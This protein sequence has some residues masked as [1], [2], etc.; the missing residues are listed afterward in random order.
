[1]V[2]MDS[3]LFH[4]A[5]DIMRTRDAQLAALGDDELMHYGR[6]GMKWNENIYAED[7]EKKRRASAS[8]GQSQYAKQLQAEANK[9]RYGGSAYNDSKPE[10]PLIPAA[11]RLPE[12]P[13]PITGLE[14]RFDNS[15]S[16]KADYYRNKYGSQSSGS[17][18]DDVENGRRIREQQRAQREAAAKYGGPAYTPSQK[19]L[20]KLNEDN[21]RAKAERQI[22]EAKN[23]N[24]SEENQK[25][26]AARERAKVQED[27]RK[28]DRIGLY[29]DPKV[30]GSGP[31]QNGDYTI[32]TET[33]LPNSRANDVNGVTEG[34]EHFNLE[35]VDEKSD[36]L[37]RARDID[38]WHIE[39]V[40]EPYLKEK[41]ERKD[42]IDSY[43][44][45]Y[46]GSV[47]TPGEE[48]LARYKKSADIAKKP[49]EARERANQIRDAREHD[50]NVL[51]SDKYS[52]SGRGSY[53]THDISYTSPSGNRITKS[54]PRES[55]NYEFSGRQGHMNIMNARGENLEKLLKNIDI[56]KQ[57]KK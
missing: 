45:K 5:C 57:K 50:R 29:K 9:R 28:N 23:T 14:K 6:K 32:F 52:D 36:R 20:D 2:K 10:R 26:N 56:W 53:D 11:S 34:R 37:K 30:V 51:S 13:E 43:K 41:N 39:N 38:Q 46:A 19:D 33:V 31:D 21:R 12:E 24:M 18:P 35:D 4:A 7:E 8:S 25:A 44:K 49:Y 16:A 15:A 17:T 55:D 27:A 1:M 22:R 42:R 47:Y 3:E 48:E 54:I 40:Q